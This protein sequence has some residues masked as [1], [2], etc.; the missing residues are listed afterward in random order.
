M[1]RAGAEAPHALGVLDELA[2][3]H[4]RRASTAFMNDFAR[5]V[6]GM[7]I[8]QVPFAIM[9]VI[10]SHPGIRQGEVGERLG[11]QRANMVA[12]VNEL[13]EA[14]WVERRPSPADR[15]ALALEMTPAGRK[16][17][18]DALGKIRHHEEAML[19]GLS[20]AEREALIA[21]LRQLSQRG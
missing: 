15:R 2:G 12:L 7:G 19:S 8:R 16:T 17:F 1:T 10:E 14:G 11:I 21:L 9:A 4:L 6:E 20:P 18:R 5:V 13:V 3:Y